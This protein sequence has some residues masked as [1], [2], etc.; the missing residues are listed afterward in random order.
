[1]KRGWFK[2]TIFPI[3]FRSESRKIYFEIGV[4]IQSFTGDK[5]LTAIVKWLF[6]FPSGVLNVSISWK[7]IDEALE[8]VV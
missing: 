4:T 3:L 1:M 8:Q 7:I 2:E 6:F 5:I